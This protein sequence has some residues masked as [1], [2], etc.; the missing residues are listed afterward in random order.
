VHDLQRAGQRVR[1][2]ETP[3]SLEEALQL[4]DAHGPS[5]RPISGGTDLIVELDRGARPG[6]EVLVDLTRIPGLDRIEADGDRLRLGGLVTH[7]QVIG[8]ALV[9]DRALPLAQACLE[10][11]SLFWPAGTFTTARN[12]VPEGHAG[13]R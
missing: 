5:A 8:S 9:V 11:G 13:A 1:R 3:T 7:N 2:H 12:R 6:V 10:V 4:L